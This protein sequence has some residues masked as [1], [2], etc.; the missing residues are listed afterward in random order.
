MLQ[1][2]QHLRSEKPE[3]VDVPRPLLKRGHLLIKASHTCVSP[4]TE[5]NSVEFAQKGL[6]QKAQ[7]RPD[8]VKQ[9]VGKMR[10][11]GLLTAAQAALARL[12]QPLSLGYS[13][14]GTACEV[15]PEIEGFAVNDRVAAAGAGYAMHAQII[16]V[17]ANLVVPI[18]VGVDLESAAFVA[19]GAIALHGV[20]LAEVQVGECVAVIG[21]GLVGQLTAQ[22][23]RASGCRVVGI[24][25][26]GERCALAGQYI[27]GVAQSE[28]EFIGLVNRF[29]ASR[30]A[31]SV[32]IA[33]DSKGAETVE[34]A[35]KAARD[36]GR[37]VAVGGVQTNLPRQI[38][39]DKELDFRVSRSYGPGR[40]DPAY[41]EKGQDYPYAYVR[42]TERRNMLSF[43]DLLDQK[44]I[45]VSALITHRFPIEK[46]TAAYDLITGQS[47][48]SFLGVVLTYPLEAP[49]GTT[50]VLKENSASATQVRQQNL[51]VSF[52]GAGNFAR[53][54]LIP[55]A[56]SVPDVTLQGVATA[57][58]LTC[59]QVASKFGFAFC[60]TDS[61]EILRHSQTN[62]VAIATR[63]DLHARQVIQALQAG[64]NVFVEKPI[65][66][67]E[68]ELRE[69][70]KVYL[71]VRGKIQLTVGY[72]RRFAPCIL[73]LKSFATSFKEPMIAHYRVNAGFIK[74]DH[75]LQDPSVGGGRIVGEICH[76]VDL[77]MH[78]T[79]AAPVRVTA[80]GL[81]N[82][83]RYRDDN[84]VILLE[85][86]DQ[87]VGT[88]HYCANGD[89]SFPKERLELFVGGAT[90]VVDD[91]KTLQLVRN[92]KSEV[93]RSWLRKD[94]GHRG[95]WQAFAEALK[96]GSE[97]I[98]F[99]EIVVGMLATFGIQKSLRSGAPVDIQTAGFPQSD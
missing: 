19:L 10:N 70:S 66:I 9:V 40:Y 11:D 27:D 83:G 69:I 38:Y 29:S 82:G 30:G 90:G 43:L 45:D 1:L 88:I 60:T 79:G 2:I 63:H 85:F 74:A 84:L 76:F 28:S 73:K 93:V 50:V 6:L 3:I 36:R 5:R 94:K 86:A 20:R 97:A 22:M 33:A 15:S 8:L 12:D 87:S 56:R 14:S 23:L 53:S 26:K 48:T 96:Q 52:L 13:A 47:G 89:A 42:W 44:K 4:G 99:G 7:A 32:I 54:V 58:G 17:P 98:P 78:L 68:E 31:D 65:C 77:L 95:E 64:K 72:N 25:L 16:S 57:S 91:F 62:T 81:P 49:M 39:Y 61:G 92:G 71:T 55:A 75:W 46:A 21:L 35:G 59:R 24:D 37:V 51:S 34:L 67:S 41:E 80:K 18:P